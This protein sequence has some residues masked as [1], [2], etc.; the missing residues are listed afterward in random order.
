MGTRDSCRGAEVA[1]RGRVRRMQRSL[2]GRLDGLDRT[3]DPTTVHEVRIAARRLRIL[4][5]AFKK[6]LCAPKIDAYLKAL[7]DL[8]HD[9]DRA[10]DAE[11]AYRTLAALATAH[12]G[13]LQTQ[14]A[15][16]VEL[17]AEERARAAEELGAAIRT[18]RWRARR[19]AL[20]RI[21]GDPAIL[22]A[23]EP[24]GP[25]TDRVM[26]RRRRRLGRALRRAGSGMAELHK[27][28]LKVKALRYLAEQFPPGGGDPPRDEL[29][30][31]HG[32]QDCLGALHD[33]WCLK[34]TLKALDRF[35][36]PVRA[37]CAL[38]DERRK[39]LLKEF[40]MRRKT[41]VRLWR[42]ADLE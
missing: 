17:A 28:R 2:D 8:S 36:R 19:S 26:R 13:R 31:L 22:D 12:G 1:L 24:I 11:V 20:R 27:L 21:A 34:H 18:Q 5:R 15:P 30:H 14:S 9:L 35:R 32:L 38:L 42:A 39:A 6:A 4:L 41:L 33:A 7:S 23:S 37:L 16:L 29:D 10:R 40:R 3:V 25:L